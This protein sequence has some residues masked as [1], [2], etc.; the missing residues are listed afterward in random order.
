[1]AGVG[2]GRFGAGLG[3]SESAVAAQVKRFF[4]SYRRIRSLHDRIQGLADQ[5][6]LPREVWER[7]R[8]IMGVFW[9]LYEKHG[10]KA[11][12]DES[13]QT[14]VVGWFVW[15]N[16]RLLTM[17]K[18]PLLGALFVISLIVAGVVVAIGITWVVVDG[19]NDLDA[20]LSQQEKELEYREQVLRQ[21]QSGTLSP[22]DAR[23]LMV[24]NG[25]SDDG[26]ILDILGRNVTVFLVVAA[27][28]V[29]MAT[30]MRRR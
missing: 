17:S 15:A 1:M 4:A 22:A 14:E 24:D 5:L 19:L 8:H 10:L 3:V 28:T 13:Q 11:C 23:G 25:P 30:L 29:V 7:Q 9:S 26:G 2:L 6:L 20:E 27:G 16:V 12:L 18:A 21:V